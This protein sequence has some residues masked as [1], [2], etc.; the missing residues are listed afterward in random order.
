M[1]LYFHTQR[2]HQHCSV[3]SSHTSVYLCFLCPVR[4][5]FWRFVITSQSVQWV[6]PIVLNHIELMQDDEV[7]EVTR[8][9]FIAVFTILLWSF[10][11]CIAALSQMP[12]KQSILTQFATS[13]GPS[14]SLSKVSCDLRPGWS[15]LLVLKDQIKFR[16]YSFQSSCCSSVSSQTKLH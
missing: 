2:H 3:A 8:I 1:H 14:R 7:V 11:I 15:E 16:L 12:V 5:M 4:T 9:Q 13:L 10:I 6:F